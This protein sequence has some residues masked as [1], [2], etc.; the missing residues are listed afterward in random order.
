MVCV[1]ENTSNI[2]TVDIVETE[3]KSVLQINIDFFF[4]QKYIFGCITCGYKIILYQL[5]S[6]YYFHEFGGNVNALC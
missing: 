6:K 5:R 4:F 1:E 3:M 2:T